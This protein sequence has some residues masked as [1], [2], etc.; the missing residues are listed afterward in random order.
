MW[1]ADSFDGVPPPT[2][3]EDAGFDISKRFYP[4]L[5]VSKETVAELFE[6][7]GLLDAQ[8]SEQAARRRQCRGGGGAGVAG[9]AGS[10]SHV[11]CLECICCQLLAKAEASWRLRAGPKSRPR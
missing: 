7:Y 2:L 11:V 6:R 1:V 9:G 8:V 4:F 3:P 5:A 10:D